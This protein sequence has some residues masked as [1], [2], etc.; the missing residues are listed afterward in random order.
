MPA[1]V[2]LRL[3]RV[4][5]SLSRMNKR[6]CRR[7]YLDAA[8][9][10]RVREN[11]SGSKSRLASMRCAL[12]SE[13]E[14]KCFGILGIYEGPHSLSRYSCRFSGIP[15]PR[16]ASYRGLVENLI[17]AHVI[18]LATENS[19]P[20]SSHAFE[21]DSP[22]DQLQQLDERLPRDCLRPQ[23]TDVH[24]CVDLLGLNS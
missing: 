4:R 20:L 2:F 24:G 7:A 10:P 12:R 14:R 1:M 19:R 22:A 3:L 8:S 5:S 13:H 15:T 16:T 11:A 9:R 6:P 21:V 18:S 17:E 23:V